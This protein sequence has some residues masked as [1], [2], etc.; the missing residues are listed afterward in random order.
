MA[1]PWHGCTTWGRTGASRG[2]W[3]RRQGET[4]DGAPASGRPGMEDPLGRLSFW[5]F[6]G[7]EEA[8]GQGSRASGGTG[9]GDNPRRGEPKSG[10]DARSE[11]NDE[12]LSVLPVRGLPSPVPW[13]S[14][15]AEPMSALPHR[16]SAQSFPRRPGR[17]LTPMHRR[18]AC[19]SL[20]GRSL[21]RGTPGEFPSFSLLVRLLENDLQRAQAES[22]RPAYR[23]ASAWPL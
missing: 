22:F 5:W 19:P 20:T 14:G 15:Q 4:W 13:P 16:H 8:R 17:P 12:R 23:V 11:L 2:G 10:R 21:R 9:A 18:V 6:G 7:R 3:R 1:G